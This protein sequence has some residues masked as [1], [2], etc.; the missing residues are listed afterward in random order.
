MPSHA[1]WPIELK[2]YINTLVKTYKYRSTYT[3]STSFIYSEPINSIELSKN[4]V[5]TFLSMGKES[6]WSFSILLRNTDL[7]KIVVVF[8]N[9]AN[10]GINYREKEKYKEFSTWFSKNNVD[11]RVNFLEVQYDFDLVG[12]QSRETNLKI[13]NENIKEPLTKVQYMQLLTVPAI[14][15]FKCGLFIVPMDFEEKNCNPLSYFGD[16]PVSFLS[17][18]KF[19]SRYVG[20]EI[21]LKFQGL[22]VSRQ[23]KTLH[24]LK[25]D[26]FKFV[27]SCYMCWNFFDKYQSEC[28]INPEL[29]MCG[30]CWKCK[31]DLSMFYSSPIR[32]LINIH[33]FI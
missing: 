1:V 26:W 6:L 19:F 12:I 21:K 3:F 17:F 20:G 9:G 2:D 16:Q 4:S 7:K 10:Y 31:E 22:S 30:G 29:N 18:N 24:L 15:E 5:I 28:K 8:V 25:I 33:N 14:K 32:E 23:D 11:R 13:K 27:S